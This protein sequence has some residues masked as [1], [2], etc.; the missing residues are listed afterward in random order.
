ML[1]AS[2]SVYTLV[3]A[4]VG[5]CHAV[6]EKIYF[7]L[8]AWM[9]SLQSSWVTSVLHSNHLVGNLGI[10]SFASFQ[11]DVGFKIMDLK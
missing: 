5:L 9:G 3:V 8:L 2:G 6:C 4:D 10:C 1:L 7:C 11:T